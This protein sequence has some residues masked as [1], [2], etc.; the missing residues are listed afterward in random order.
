MKQE[1]YEFGILEHGLE[2]RN[3]R[4]VAK[5]VSCLLSLIIAW[6]FTYRAGRIILELS[7]EAHTAS[8]AAIIDFGVQF[9][10]TLQNVVGDILT[11]EVHLIFCEFS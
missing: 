10:C 4:Y 5:S 11:V 1:I 6:L 2:S 8:D 7:S 3:Y 9:R